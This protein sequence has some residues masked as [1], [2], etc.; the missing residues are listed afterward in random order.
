MAARVK[1]ASRCDNAG[2][3][4]AW[5]FI[6]RW[7]GNLL[8]VKALWELLLPAGGASVLTGYLTWTAHQP[9]WIIALASVIVG[10]VVF[11]VIRRF[12][13]A[14]PYPAPHPQAA[15]LPS[16]Q[17][18]HGEQSPIAWTGSA[19]SP[20]IAAGR[21]VTY[22]A[23]LNVPPAKEEP[24][25]I[26]HW[27]FCPTKEYK[28]FP[29]FRLLLQNTGKAV[30]VNISALPMRFDIPEGRRATVKR[31][32]EASL[33]Q[34]GNSIAGEIDDYTPKVWEV[35]F[36]SIDR[37]TVGSSEQELPYRL[38]GGMVWPQQDIAHILEQFIRTEDLRMDR[39]FAVV[40]SD[41]GNPQRTWH[42]HYTLTFQFN[43]QKERQSIGLKFLQCA[44]AIDGRC[45][46]CEA[47]TVLRED[48]R[49][50]PLAELQQPP[51]LPILEDTGNAKYPGSDKSWVKEF[52]IFGV[53]NTQTDALVTAYNVRAALKYTH[54]N[55]IDKFIVA[56]ATWIAD[57]PD[58]ERQISIESRVDLES[59]KR[60]RVVLAMTKKLDNTPRTMNPPHGQL[61]PDEGKVLKYGRS[62]IQGKVTADNC[63]SL[64]VWYGLQIDEHGD[65]SSFSMQQGH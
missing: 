40:F 20:A 56:P 7:I 54:A 1:A 58:P 43:P 35:S 46:G 28:D 5:S 26:A 48:F 62:L 60:A 42:T 55:G 37:L 11:L 50:P 31:I 21:D 36:R 19:N 6:W 30:A 59:S 15:P 38:R 25:I 18:T 52:V 51:P 53:R 27:E 22:Q 4:K 29:H 2:M 3:L 14:V 23:Y 12:Q 8:R 33:K 61:S 13:S 63:D 9:V 44:E 16:S 47:I 45:P 64:E 24:Q 57:S 17:S 39:E 32:V 41:T 65:I 34:A 10:V 49:E